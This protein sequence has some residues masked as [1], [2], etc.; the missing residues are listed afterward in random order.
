MKTKLAA[1]LLPA[2]VALFVSQLFTDVPG[3]S[4]VHAAEAP[5]FSDTSSHWGAS[6]IAWGVQNHIVDGY[7]DGSFRPDEP[8]SEPEFLAMLLRAYPEIKL[9]DAAAGAAWYKPYYDAADTRKW[10]VLHNADPAKFNRGHVARII[11]ASQKGTQSLNDSI[12]YLLDQGLSGGKTA[13]TVAGYQAADRLSR[14]EAVQFIRNLKLKQLR[15]SP[16][17][18]AA[19]AAPAVPAPSDPKSPTAPVPP[20]ASP[21]GT[22]PAAAEAVTVKGIRLG[23]TAADVIATLGEPARKDLSEYGFHWYIYNQDYSSYAQIGIGSDGKVV[24][25]YSP[26]ANWQLNG[27]TDGSAKSAVQKQYGQP[28]ASITKGNTRLMMNYG[29]GEYGTY[30]TD[31]AYVTFFYDLHRSN[32]VTSV[33]AIAKPAEMALTTFYPESSD[34]L[35]NAYERQIFDLANAVRVKLGKPAFVWDDKVA[36]TARKHSRDMADHS[37]FNHTNLSGASPFDRMKQDGLTLQAAAEN[38]AAGQTSAIFAH[39]SWMN[40]EGHR[41]NVLSDIERLGVG[42]AFGGKMSIYYTQNFYTPK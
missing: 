23:D 29:K 20:H 35:I 2:A 41:I 4:A 30:E 39:E 25:L 21:A 17:G 1:F 34:T 42:V 31:D 37:F 8:V 36:S 16:D 27:L 9:P 33:Q 6:A 24:G 26:S 12:R 38:I 19:P 7:A 10:P 5:V 14:A 18:T 32:V 22:A 40:S 13:A 15:L 28:L 3:H 11:T